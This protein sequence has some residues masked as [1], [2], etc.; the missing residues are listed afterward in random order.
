MLQPSAVGAGFRRH[1]AGTIAPTV[2]QSSRSN[3]RD[4]SMR[5]T[6]MSAFEYAEK[7]GCGR[8][9]VTPIQAKAHNAHCGQMPEDSQFMTG[10]NGFD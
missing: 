2:A 3:A 6:A 4:M 7:C 5:G 1:G 8:I 9:V 10:G